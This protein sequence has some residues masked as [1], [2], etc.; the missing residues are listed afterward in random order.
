MQG[1][2]V[3][4]LVCRDDLDF[5][6]P[7]VWSNSPIFV[8]LKMGSLLYPVKVSVESKYLSMFSIELFSVKSNPQNLL[9]IS[10][11]YLTT[12]SPSPHIYQQCAAHAFTI[13]GIYIIFTV[14][15]IWIVQITCNCSC[16]HS[17][18]LLQF[19]FGVP[20]G[21]VLGP[22]LFTLY[23]TPL[24]SLISGHYPAPPLCWW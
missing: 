12:I 6:F 21:S 8:Y 17:S 19:T 13:C 2:P 24:S 3:K 18:R 16:V 10:E 9:G 1:F 15:L 20:Q 11:Y 23:T 7:K 5:S 22:L 4:I 14:T